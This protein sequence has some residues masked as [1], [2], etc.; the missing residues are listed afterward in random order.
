MIVLT[1]RR[2]AQ[3]WEWRKTLTIRRTG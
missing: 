1:W 3:E 2:F